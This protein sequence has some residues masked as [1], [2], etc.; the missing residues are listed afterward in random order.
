MEE[1]MRANRMSSTPAAISRSPGCAFML[2]FR[3]GLLF[4]VLGRATNFPAGRNQLIDHSTPG[5]EGGAG[6]GA[7]RWNHSPVG[8]LNS[9]GSGWTLGLPYPYSFGSIGQ[10]FVPAGK[11]L[12]SDWGNDS[13]PAGNGLSPP[14]PP[15]WKSN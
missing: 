11:N 9:Q 10:V 13:A 2:P 3:Q 14:F 6:W 12:R 4:A 7:G 1:A 8:W 15:P 5:A